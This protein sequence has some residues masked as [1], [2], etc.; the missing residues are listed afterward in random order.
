MATRRHLKNIANGLLGSFVSRNNDICGYWGLGIL[1]ALAAN[2]GLDKIYF[3]L[4]CK[5]IE[6]SDCSSFASTEQ[7]YRRRFLDLL[8]RVGADVG[9]IERAEIQIE[10][11]GFDKYPT[12]IRDTRGEPYVCT[13]LL[14]TLHGNTY[15]ASKIGVCAQHDPAKDRRRG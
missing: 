2:N 4:N 7:A 9:E 5:N 12:V 13:V 10:F 15:T 14:S 3:D 8:S 1:R 6:F 11:A